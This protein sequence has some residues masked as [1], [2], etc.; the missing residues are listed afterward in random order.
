[1]EYL[2]GEAMPSKAQG[3]Q[4][5]KDDGI[6]HAGQGAATCLARTHR[7]CVYPAG[8]IPIGGEPCRVG[9][10]VDLYKRA[11]IVVVR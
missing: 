5:G 7:Q 3:V 6:G 8:Y 9:V 2:L 1:M 11:K 10:K 4:W